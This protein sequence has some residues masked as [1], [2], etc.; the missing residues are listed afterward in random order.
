M[1]AKLSYLFQSPRGYYEYRRQVPAKLRPYFPLTKGK[2]LMTE[3]KASLQTTDERVAHKQWLKVNEQYEAT[4]NLA[5]KLLAKRNLSSSEA[6]TAGK[7]ITLE[8]G[9]HPDQAPVLK[10][11]ATQEEINS[12]E[13]RVLAWNKNL[14]EKRDLLLDVLYDEHIDEEQQRRDYDSGKWFQQDYKIPMKSFDPTSPRVAALNIV[15]GEVLTKFYPTWQ[16]AVELYIKVN[17]QENKR[18]AEKEKRWELKTRSLLARFAKGNGGLNLKLDEIDRQTVRNWL[19]TTYPKA[20]T[21]NRYNNV[22]SAVINRWNKEN[23]SSVFNPFSGLSNKQLEKE[24][25]LDRRSFKP[26]EW[27]DYLSH[28][29]ELSDPQ[30][31]LIGLLM[32]YT[33]CRTNEACGLQV[34]DLK[35]E[36]NVPHIVFRTNSIRRMD[37]DGF[38]RAVP[39]LT[40]L[41]DALRH[42][43]T[44]TEQEAPLFPNFGSTKGFENAS[45]KLRYIVNTVMAL[46]DPSVV[47]YSTRHTFRD[48]SEVAGTVAKSRAEYIMGHVSDGSSRIHKEYG[49]KTPPQILLDDM[50]KIYEVTDWGYYDN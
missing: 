7:N 25:A 24:E 11:D 3:W 8:A 36:S 34:K 23:S 16:D 2:R 49:T 28:V 15:D 44:L 21:R 32:I 19:H 17:K 4:K 46:E 20:G 12:F 50:I 40:P 39:L 22:F 5:E 45:V 6:I 27:Y 47:P 43:E 9:I 38:E 10:A 35:I 18:E 31:R 26:I 29:N 13:E 41:L 37:K 42:Y 48:R 33:G 14:E 1:A 30:I